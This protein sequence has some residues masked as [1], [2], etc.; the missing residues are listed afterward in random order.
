M[1]T[2]GVF[3]TVL[4]CEV[5]VGAALFLPVIKPVGAQWSSNLDSAAQNTNQQHLCLQSNASVNALLF[6]FD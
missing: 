4:A 6:V 5:V 3:S 2:Q 1:F